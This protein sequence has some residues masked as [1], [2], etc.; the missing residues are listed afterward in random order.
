VSGTEMPRYAGPATFARLPELRDVPR[1]DVA[2][3]GVPFDAGDVACNPFNIEEAMGQIRTAATGLL[4]RV[5]AI[6]TMGGD[7]TIALPLLRAVNHHLGPVALVHFDAHLDN[8]DSSFGAP[9]VVNG[10]P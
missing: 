6:V 2:V 10:W 4:G 1:C 3:L 8:R 9:R 7:H 5:G